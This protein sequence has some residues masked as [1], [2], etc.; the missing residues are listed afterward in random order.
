MDVRRVFFSRRRR[1]AA[2]A[3]ERVAG[4]IVEKFL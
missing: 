1:V 2:A 3:G 4:T